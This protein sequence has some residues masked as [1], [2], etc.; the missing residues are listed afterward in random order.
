MLSACA[1]E[2]SVGSGCF[3]QSSEVR[4]LAVRAAILP[5]ERR[6]GSREKFKMLKI[7]TSLDR[8]LTPTNTTVQF[9]KF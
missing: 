5:I 8:G 1:I 3:G 9:D 6:T 7:V 4:G 2:G